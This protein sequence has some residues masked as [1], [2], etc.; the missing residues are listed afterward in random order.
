MNAKR[1]KQR[2]ALLIIDMQNDFVMSGSPVYV[3]G[4]YSTIDSIRILLDFYRTTGEPVF[5]VI[6]EYRS[7]G[8]DIEITRYEN[9]MKDC[10]VVVPNTNGSKIVEKLQPAEGEY[11]IIKNRFSAFMNTELDF[12]LRR[13]QISELTICGT[14]LPNCIRAT[15]YDGISYGYHVTVIKD[16]CSAATRQI[17]EA[18]ITDLQNVG[19][20][21]I[22]IEEFLDKRTNPL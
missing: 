13:L 21:C 4:A 20:P 7:D 12:M 16:A 1:D 18:N 5:H 8:S 19:I 6:R 2:S 9:F 10:K 15:A 3:S 17:A 14:Q 11:V 22:T